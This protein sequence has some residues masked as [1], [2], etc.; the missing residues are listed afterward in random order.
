MSGAG[1][2]SRSGHGV[3]KGPQLVQVASGPSRHTLGRCVGLECTRYDARTRIRRRGS[4]NA[5]Q[6]TREHSDAR[7]AL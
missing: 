4:H 6:W 7:H 5:A 1:R 3:K 2:Q